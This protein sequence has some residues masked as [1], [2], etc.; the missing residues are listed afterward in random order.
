MRIVRR[1]KK[2]DL[3]LSFSGMGFVFLCIVTL[4]LLMEF[5]IIGVRFLFA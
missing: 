1:E 2:L 3:G 5:V 4:L